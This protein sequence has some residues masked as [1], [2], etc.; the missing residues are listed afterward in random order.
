VFFLYVYR[1]VLWADYSS[2]YQKPF[3][4][5]CARFAG[6]NCHTSDAKLC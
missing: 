4:L 1:D 5:G 3:H 6:C 2:T